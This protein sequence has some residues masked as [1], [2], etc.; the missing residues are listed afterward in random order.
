MTRSSR[1]MISLLVTVIYLLITMSPLVPLAL[2]SPRVAHAVTGE[3][4]GDCNICGCS[5]ERRANH[6]CCCWLKKMKHDH[7]HEEEQ[8]PAC[9]KKK[10]KPAKPELKCNCPCGSGKQI[11]IWGAEKHEQIPCQYIAGIPFSFGNSLAGVYERRLTDRY[12][13]PPD[14]PPKISSIS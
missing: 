12:G 9:C 14:P 3:C 8:L 10:H 6:T 5:P 7:D 1:K 13:D 2:K 11:A 4:S